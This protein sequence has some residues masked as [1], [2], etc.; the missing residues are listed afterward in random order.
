MKQI[1]GKPMLELQIERIRQ[2]IRIDKLVV[3]TSFEPE[4]D[5]IEELCDNLGV[6]CFRG[7]LNDVL[8]RFYQA[9]SQ[10]K[11]Q[12]IVRLTG[13]CPLTDPEVIDYGIA[14]YENNPYDYVSNSVERTYPIG[15][16]L[17]V[18]SFKHLKEAAQKAE[19]P[20]EREHV[21]AYFRNHRDEYKVGQFHCDTDLS[22]H[23][24]TVDEPADFEFVT[25]IYEALYLTNP[26]FTTHDILTL[27]S[28]RPDLMTINYAI[29]HNQG[30]EKSLREDRE[31]LEAREKQPV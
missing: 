23:R 5:P 11:P 19:L 25:K 8:D 30:Y 6:D 21:T 16:D 22:E 14:F 12:L 24:W 2:S 9:A 27:I 7:N 28:E 26:R 29:M 31:Y 1:V 20:S 3:A 10:Y 18:F 4:D 17:E 13:D 15:L